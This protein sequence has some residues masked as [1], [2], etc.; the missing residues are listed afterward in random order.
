MTLIYRPHHPLANENGMVERH[1]GGPVETTK[2][3]YAVHVI[4]DTMAHLKHPGTGA[5]LDSKSRFREHTRDSG[6]LE[7]GTDPAGSKPK[8]RFDV[9]TSEVVQDVKRAIQEVRSR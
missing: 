1:L 4:S 3:L 8:P 6:C 2:P 7:V 5:M 9:S